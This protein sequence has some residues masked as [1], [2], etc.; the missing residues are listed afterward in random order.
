MEL[1]LLP[2]I[3]AP[4]ALDLPTLPLGM[5]VAHAMCA[6]AARAR[7]LDVVPTHFLPVR[8]SNF[9]GKGPLVLV[10]IDGATHDC[11]E[12]PLAQNVST[13]SAT[14]ALRQQE[15]D[16]LIMQSRKKSLRVELISPTTQMDGVP[17]H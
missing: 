4:Q 16:K 9:D 10:E 2:A 12:C 17:V 14:P 15:P 5:A 11:G 13:L 3:F 6:A 1:E 8:E 7:N